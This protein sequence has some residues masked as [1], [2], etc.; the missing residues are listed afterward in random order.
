MRVACIWFPNPR[1]VASFA[2]DCLR[3]T[4][5]IC[6]REEQAV[7][8]EI[9]KCYRLYS[10]EAFVGRAQRL[11]EKLDIR[12]SVGVA[13]SIEWALVAAKY[14]TILPEHLPLEALYDIAD[15]LC[16]DEKCVPFV[17][18]LIQA[19][20]DLGVQNL[21]AFQHIPRKE[22]AS[23]FGPVGLLCRQR[24]DGELVFPWKA[25]IPPEVVEET[26]AYMY[27]ECP[28]A[29]EPLL[30]E[31][32]KLLDRLFVRLRARGLKAA[33]LDIDILCE[34]VSTNPQR[35]RKLHL[36]FLLPQGEA[37]GALGILREFFSK[38]FDRR[39]LLSNVERFCIRVSK[40]V[41]CDTSQKNLYHGREERMEALGNLLSQLSQAHGKGS[42]FQA[43]T[44][45]ERLPEHS[46]QK[47]AQ[48]QGP[49]ANLRGRVPL[50]PTN[51]VKPQRIEV[52]EH[53]VYIKK[54]PF[55]VK[56]WSEAAER[57]SARW[58]DGLVDRTYYQ[59]EVENG[60]LLWIFCESGN[61]YYL[62]GFYG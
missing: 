55:L 47:V 54:K 61:H 32:K 52:T 20:P 49:G 9:G 6:I 53:H 42:I 60:P 12:A 44:V 8:L 51:L 45:E 7:F 50:R 35:E 10:E 33:A 25:W 59:V 41:P 5:Q 39:P 38:E 26:I 2:E 22:L 43:L 56:S 31:A 13:G 36:D 37:K 30:F 4:P 16:R 28:G 48:L 62:H 21:H 40:T 15:P 19:L 46:W 11:L 57:I 34:K 29:Q 58:L 17:K 18:K 14:G 24:L 3:F 1:D 27:A 23:R